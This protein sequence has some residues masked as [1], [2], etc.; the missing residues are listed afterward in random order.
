MTKFTKEMRAEA[1]RRIKGNPLMPKQE[2]RIAIGN[3]GES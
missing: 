2:K 3:L 1:I